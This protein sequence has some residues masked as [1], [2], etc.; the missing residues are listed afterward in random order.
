MHCFIYISSIV[1]VHCLVHNGSIL[2]GTF[3]IHDTFYNVKLICIVLY[4]ICCM[5]AIL[6]R[7]VVSLL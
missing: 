5:V 1:H 7:I 4:N 6:P 2:T 3:F